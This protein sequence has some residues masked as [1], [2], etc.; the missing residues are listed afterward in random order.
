MCN[1]PQ[2][3]PVGAAKRCPICHGKFGLVRRYCWLPL[4]KE[5]R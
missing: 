4:L 5:V 1:N 3:H 2:Y